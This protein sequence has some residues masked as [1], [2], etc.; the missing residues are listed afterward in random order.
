MSQYIINGGKALKGEVSIRGA[1]NAS[2]KQIIATL[3]TDKTCQLDNVPVIADVKITESIAKQL[4]TQIK[5]VGEHSIELTTSTITSTTVPFG[6][7]QK[8]RSSFL[9]A[10]PLLARK[11]QATFP[12]P[13]GDKLGDR[14]LDRFFDCLKRMNVK[15]HENNGIIT[16]TTTNLKATQYR[17]NK[18]SHTV[19]EAVL[20]LATLTAGT[21]IFQN[22]AREPEIDDLIEFL[23]DMGA[24]INR[25]SKYPDQIQIT[26]VSKLTGAKHQVIA[27]RNEAVTFACAALATK[28]S[29]NILR[30]NPAI[31]ETFL[32]TVEQMGARVDR[33]KEEL[34]ISWVQPLKAVDIETGPEPM[35]MTDWQPVFT[36]VLSQA[37]GCSHLIERVFPYRFHHIEEFKKM[38]LKAEYFNPIVDNPA[39]YYE[40]NPESNRPEYFHGVKIFGPAK[41]QPA[42]FMV[43]DL[44]TGASLTLAALT[45]EGKSSIE[46]VENIERGYEKLADRLCYLGANIEYIK[47]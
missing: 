1:K 26:G 45:A 42:D 24:K 41:L 39:S 11:G 47:T 3:L 43:N 9:F 10:A 4:G 6:T 40:F 18:P 25:D 21:S 37:I 28:G 14:P 15:I 32:Q 36:V 44:R 2:F 20:L 22:C 8:S 35:F 17:F 23:K 34:I 46:G 38:G 5:P 31:I 13:G 29:V 16:L 30:I 33:G 7:G 27:D 12:L 19:T